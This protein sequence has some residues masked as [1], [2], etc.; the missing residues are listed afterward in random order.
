MQTQA[1]WYRGWEQT[2]HA[3]ALYALLH[4]WQ[5]IYKRSEIS[6]EGLVTIEWSDRHQIREGLVVMVR[7]RDELGN[8]CSFTNSLYITS[9]EKRMLENNLRCSFLCSNSSEVNKYTENTVNNVWKNMKTRAI[10]VRISFQNGTNKDTCL[11][12]SGVLVDSGGQNE[13]VFLQ[14]LQQDKKQ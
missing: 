8:R 1:E 4:A 7:A 14:Y 2:T 11:G 13:T 10:L 5:C 3:V 9:T 6:K 12:I